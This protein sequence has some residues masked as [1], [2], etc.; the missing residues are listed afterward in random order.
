MT[1]VFVPG[2]TFMMGSDPV[3]DSNARS[4]ER[5][6]HNVTL[7]AF[8]LDQTEVTNEQFGRFVTATAYETTA[9]VE[10]S[11]YIYT[12]SSWE[13]VSGADWQHPGGPESSLDR[14]ETH[15]VVLVSWDDAVASCDWAGG[16][17]PRE[18]QWEYAARGE[19][20]NIFPWG[21]EFDG[22]QLNYCDSH[23]EFDWKDESVDD[24]YGRTAP[25]ASYDSQSWA[26]AYDLA[27][28]VWEWTADWYGDYN[29]TSQNNP[30]G[31]AN[32]EY[33]VLRGGSWRLTPSLVRGA[34]RD[35]VTPGLRGI[36][37]GFRCVASPGS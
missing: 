19:A 21:N 5:P 7:D 35:N 33:K 13:L 17:L 11:G 16:Q 1:M 25:V 23:C 6:R 31:P 15:P 2:G 24:G 22:T 14:L 3:D 4:D 12:G 37:V 32:G 28:N 29:N 8:W 9:E 20:G 10:G 30:T 18:A 27:G 36:D 34:Y 26:G